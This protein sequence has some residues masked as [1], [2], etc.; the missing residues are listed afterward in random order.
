MK[1]DTHKTQI[2]ASDPS[3]WV[4][5]YG[6]YLYGYALRR[7]PD[8]SLA[9]DLVQETFLAALKSKD[10]FRGR[11]SEKTWM[12]GILKHK[13]MD[14]LRKKYRE[15]TWENPDAALKK[16][17]PIFAA[18]GKWETKPVKW[19]TNPHDL[20]EQKAFMEA[21]Y[22]CIH[23]LPRR[24]GDAF[25]LRELEGSSTNQICKILGISAT[26]CYVILHRA[27]SMIRGCLEKSW[28]NGKEST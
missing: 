7:V 4:D 16:E 3:Q 6:D 2:P 21:V 5:R 22:Q 18:D 12:T 24:L 27:R 20:Y 14:H 17:R 23:T 10:N 26:N 11:S 25:T 9:Q 28:F 19:A 1:R 15:T 13:L 8:P